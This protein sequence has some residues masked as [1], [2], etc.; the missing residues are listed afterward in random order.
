VQVIQLFQD[1][2]FYRELVI[3]LSENSKF[4][5][6]N[7]VLLWFEGSGGRIDRRELVNYYIICV[8]MS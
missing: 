4:S 6:L 8:E 1:F 7:C 5:D 2:E 3:A